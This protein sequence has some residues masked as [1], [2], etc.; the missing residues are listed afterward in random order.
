MSMHLS[1]WFWLADR[2]ISGWKPS[3]DDWAL[4]CKYGAHIWLVKAE[5]QMESQQ[6]V[7]G[8]L[9]H[10]IIGFDILSRVLYILKK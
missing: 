2:G 7:N 6:I 10:P 3:T 9:A 1:Y 8:T 4:Y 5:I